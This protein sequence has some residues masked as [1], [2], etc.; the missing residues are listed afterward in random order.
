MSLGRVHALQV[1]LFRS[2]V[3]R[4]LVGHG[5][6]LDGVRVGSVVSHLE[7]VVTWPGSR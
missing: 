7:G 5:R 1:A 3:S 6:M 4:W 2:I